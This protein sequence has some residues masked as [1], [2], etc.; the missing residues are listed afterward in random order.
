MGLEKAFAH[1]FLQLTVSD[2]CTVY[3]LHLL[4]VN[5][6]PDVLSILFKQFYVSYIL[7]TD[8]LI[9]IWEEERLIFQ[10]YFFLWNKFLL[11]ILFIV[12][13]NMKY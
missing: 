2:K 4:F 11:Q 3:K 13:L 9:L 1:P 7:F 12:I 10:K 5:F 6:D 8:I